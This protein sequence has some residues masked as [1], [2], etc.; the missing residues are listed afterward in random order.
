MPKSERKEPK[1]GS[2]VLFGLVFEN[3]GYNVFREDIEKYVVYK[4]KACTKWW[5]R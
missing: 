5:I 3:A 2:Q 4:Q 1:E